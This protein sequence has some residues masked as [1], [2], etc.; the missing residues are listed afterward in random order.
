MSGSHGKDR[1]VPAIVGAAQVVQ[2]PGDWTDASDTRGPI[3]L[4][5]DPARAAAE[6]AGAPA[7]LGRVGW[8]GVAAG[9]WRYSNPG[10]L[11]AAQLGCP[12]AR[13]ALTAISGTGPG[14][15]RLGRRAHR[16]R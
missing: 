9:W 13:T 5:V 6:D 15:R 2:R 8:I 14:P 3:E 12:D 11:I 7:L 16:A 10:Q 1:A 4:M